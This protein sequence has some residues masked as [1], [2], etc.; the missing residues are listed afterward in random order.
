M[1]FRARS[2]VTIPIFLYKHAHE[3]VSLNLSRNPKLDL[4][5]DFVQLCTS[6]R[7]LRMSDMSIK[8]IPLSVREG[9]ALTRLDVS[10]NRILE[11]DHAALDDA[12]ELI[13]LE[14][15]NNR[16]YALPAYFSSL[17]SLKYLNV[18]NNRFEV[19]PAVL[20]TIPSLVDLDI[21]FNAITELPESIGELRGLQ[22]F[23]LAAN[24]LTVLPAAFAQLLSLQELDCRY[25]SI[26]NLTMLDGLPKLSTLLCDHNRCVAISLR[27]ESLRRLEA[28]HNGSA[29]FSIQGSA[30]CLTSL[31]LSNGK[32]V[33]F[34]TDIV[35]QLQA[36]DSLVLDHNQIR[37]LHDDVVGLPNLTYL[38]CRS[39]KL[40]ALPDQIGQLVRLQRLDVSNN[41]L[42]SL[43]ASLWNCPDL[44]TLNASSNLIQE[45]PDP[46][47]AAAS[48]DA[49][50]AGD[51]RPSATAKPAVRGVAPLVSSLRGLYL[52][53]NGL[54]DETF[55]LLALLVELK[56]L[57]LSFNGIT[58]IPHRSLSK[59]VQ[60]EELYLSGNKL[61]TLP[62]DDFER[63]VNLRIIHLNGNKLQTLPA[64]L[65]TLKK[66]QALDVGSN[67]LKYNIAN[68]KFDWNWFVQSCARRA[69]LTVLSTRNWNLELRYLNLSGNK[70]LEIKPAGPQAMQGQEGSPAVAKRR[71]L[72][73]FS[74]LR[75]IRTL[76]L[77]DVT[78][79]IPSV[80]DDNEDRRVRTSNTEINEMGYGVADTLGKEDRLSMVELVS[81]R[82]RNKDDE[83]VFGIFDGQTSTSSSSARLAKYLQ[84]CF[85][86]TLHIE[87]NKMIEG[88]AD[89]SDVL[90]RTFL[91]LNRDYGNILV[92]S[93]V[94]YSRV[95]QI[96]QDTR[97]GGNSFA[98]LRSGA[99]GVVAYIAQKTLYVAN[100]GRALA[101]IAGRNGQARPLSTK[102]DPFDQSEWLR[103]RA[104]EGW[105]ST[106]G[107]VNDEVDSSRSFG[108][109]HVFPA[110][111]AQPDV[112]AIELTESDELVILA[113][114]GIWDYMDYQAA[115][116]IARGERADPM[117]AAQ[118]LRDLAISYGSTGRIM[119][120][121]VSVGD[122][123][124]AKKTMKRGGV[125]V[126]ANVDYAATRALAG[127][128]GRGQVAPG[129][130]YLTLLDREVPPPTGMLALV[131]TDIRNSTAL[132]ESNPSMQ[133]AMRMHNHLF[134]RQLRAIGGYEVKT[135]GDAFMC[136]FPSVTSAVLWCF[137]CQLELLKEDWPQSIID[138]EDGQELF[139]QA[140][141][142][143][144]RGLSV[145]MG[146]HWGQPHCEA[147]PITRRMDYFGPMVNR[148]ARISAVAEGGQIAVSSDVLD[149]CNA[150]CLNPVPTEDAV[151][152]ANALAEELSDLDEVTKRD[153]LAIRALGL[154][155]SDIGER[156]LKGLETPE[157]LSLIYPKAIAGRLSKNTLTPILPATADGA[158]GAAAARSPTLAHTF[159][160]APQLLDVQ[161]IQ[162]L[163]VL[164]LRLEAAVA[165]RYASANEGLM[166]PGSPSTI[167]DS[168]Q[169]LS[170]KHRT[171]HPHS[172]NFP[173]R[174]DSSDVELLAVLENLVAR[175][176]NVVNTLVVQ[177]MGGY[178]GSSLSHAFNAFR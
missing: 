76:G 40:E 65:G 55:H 81:P 66:L 95:R 64:E 39:N 83:C 25:N 161:Q 105:V 125:S 62:E 150:L 30:H 15:H 135:E 74:A 57:N 155:V 19:F 121:I 61:T 153:V 21:G 172:T 96:E 7:E 104:A 163:G 58:E 37:K 20:T 115:V 136:S 18:S 160:A 26:D 89:V 79:T 50:D 9:K 70:R 148:S 84:D 171:A 53:D 3:I 14:A 134:R 138:C 170:R 92:P 46:P 31:N 6:L 177:S 141:E 12:K 124:K 147:D 10:N 4:P 130:R 127:N 140:G 13:L 44:V 33:S 94:D 132:W 88:E 129:E 131:F 102:H 2:L 51:A 27:S 175:C 42:H 52:A 35:S 28:S 72:S 77:M 47:E 49:A 128:R 43:P 29:S 91:N 93:S 165:P 158:V 101:V 41:D 59:L 178:L 34:G 151:D 169:R 157:Y 107:L 166:S 126:D 159:D 78:L 142:L 120:M 85:S 63:L 123:F 56:T 112:Q 108:H 5:G 36:L 32:L 38:S 146:I 60:L 48:A 69:K 113:N 114:R 71:N 45:F 8:R 145:R 122:L 154:V 111:T 106:K 97:F 117:L 68:W 22:R 164:M 144:Y 100:A 17:R 133:T 162:G 80:P 75:K 16:I 24:A 143:L 168:N 11:L 174:A 109:Y 167:L 119:V 87:L 156:R 67:V 110:I 103:I 118:K 86:S 99:S 139:G 152:D 176:E 82:F 73:D 173:L 54:P 23:I 137:T 149:I 116:D 1:D 90:R 98:D